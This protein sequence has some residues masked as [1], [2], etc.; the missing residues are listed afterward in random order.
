MSG[1]SKVT[2][3][4]AAMGFIAMAGGYVLA[5]ETD[6]FARALESRFNA[7]DTNKDG[8]VSYHEYMAGYEKSIKKSFEKKDSNGDGAL[9]KD[10]FIS[11][12]KGFGTGKQQTPFQ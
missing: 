10:E 7:M 12:K 2:I 3:F 9:T 1:L 6:P 11:M 8:K 5:Q 4:L